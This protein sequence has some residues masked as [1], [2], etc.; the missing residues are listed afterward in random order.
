MNKLDATCERACMTNPKHKYYTELYSTTTKS[1]DR[2]VA[3]LNNEKIQDA[4]HRVIVEKKAD[5]HNIT[6]DIFRQTPI[7]TD[8]QGENKN[9]ILTSEEQNI[10][11]TL[12]ETLK[13]LT[14]NDAECYE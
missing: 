11:D 2:D 5:T 9:T 14:I 10:L 3:Q 13:G 1:N 8:T 6:V 4:I 12:A 7:T